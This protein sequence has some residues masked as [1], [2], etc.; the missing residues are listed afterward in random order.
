MLKIEGL[1]EL[2]NQLQDLAKRAE[3]LDGE[4]SIPV[5]E[6]LTDNFICQNTKFVSADE[7]FDASGFKVD[8]QEDFANIPDTEWDEYIRS[9]SNFENWQEMLEAAA[10]EWAASKLGL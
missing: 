5:S 6:L 7:L 3:E 1:D 10:Q 4:H 2:Q 9:I 8:T